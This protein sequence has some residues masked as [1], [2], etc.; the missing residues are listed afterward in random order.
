MS[1]KIITEKEIVKKEV[2][3]IEVTLMGYIGHKVRE[4]REEEDINIAQLSRRLANNGH[5]LSATTIGKIEKG[6]C[7]LKIEDLFAISNHFSTP[8][9]SFYPEGIL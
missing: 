5:S 2:T 9:S 6:L 7:P 8:M 3:E 1:F 4:K